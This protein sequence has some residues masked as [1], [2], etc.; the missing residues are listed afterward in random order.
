M[1]SFLRVV[2]RFVPVQVPVQR[3]G[4]VVPCRFMPVLECFVESATVV[5]LRISFRSCSA[6]MMRRRS[7]LPVYAV[8]DI[9]ATSI[10]AYFVSFLF[11][12]YDA[13]A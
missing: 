3:R 10:V 6:T 4:G 1:P 9:Y 5:W 12:N 2:F 7:S 13:A 8:L 11:R